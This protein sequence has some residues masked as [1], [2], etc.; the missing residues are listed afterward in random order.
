MAAQLLMNVIDDCYLK[1]GQW[2]P[3]KDFLYNVTTYDSTDVLKK[4]R[5]RVVDGSV[6]WCWMGPLR[7]P[8][9]WCLFLSSLICS[10]ID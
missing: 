10:L 2:K 4:I 9:P 5:L 3:M 1:S 7:V 6:A 8:P